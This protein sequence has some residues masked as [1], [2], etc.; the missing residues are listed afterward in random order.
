MT[1]EDFSHTLSAD[2]KEERLSY[3]LN[4]NY[5][6]EIKIDQAG[7]IA[8]SG[9]LSPTID[10]KNFGFHPNRWSLEGSGHYEGLKA[11]FTAGNLSISFSLPRN[12][13]DWHEE[14]LEF[15]L[16]EFQKEFPPG[17]HVVSCGAMIRM[18]LRVDGDARKF[19]ANH[20][21]HLSQERINSIGRPIHILGVRLMMPPFKMVKKTEQSDEDEEGDIVSSEDWEAD[22]RMESWLADPAK[23]WVEIQTSWQEPKPWTKHQTHAIVEHLQIASG[24][25]RDKIVPFLRHQD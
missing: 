2:Q 22:V 20:L 3:T 17:A 13:Q 6:P 21:M 24:F 15:I 5:L 10:L 11:V 12:A 9:R 23:L 14:R 18:L 8:F 19:L 4:V 1:N 25:V 16:S 7:G